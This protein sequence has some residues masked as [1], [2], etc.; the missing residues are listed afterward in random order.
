MSQRLKQLIAKKDEKIAR[1]E[2]ISALAADENRELTAEESTEIDACLADSEKLTADIDRETKLVNATKARL[3]AAATSAASRIQ[4][5]QNAGGETRRIV[6]P[7]EARRTGTLKCFDGP[8]AE[9]D[10]YISGQWALATIYDRQASREWLAD[11]GFGIKNALTTSDESSAGFLVPSPLESAIIRRVETYGVFRQN[12]GM[13]KPMTG[14]RWAGPRRLSGV[15]VYYPGE[16][17]AGT[18]STPTGGTISLQARDAVAWTKVSR[19]IEADAVI[20]IGD[21]LADEFGLAYA[22]AEDQ[23]GFNGDGT[24]TY[25]GMV[26]LKNKLAAGSIYTCGAGVNTFGEITNTDFQSVVGMLPEYA[27]M[28]PKWYMSKAG[29]FASAARLQA[30]AGGNTKMDI[31][32]GP[33]YQ[34]EGYEVVW[35]HVLPNALTDLASTIVAYFGDLSYA[36]AMGTA[37][38]MSIES[39]MSKYFH[40]RMIAVQAFSRYDINVYEIGTAS[41]A[42]ACI[43]LKLGTA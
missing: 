42:G 40:E 23:A 38:G 3:Q 19:N 36:A 4:E 25:G 12:V 9:K 8:D 1:A 14:G 5:P 27:G 6:I 13:Q 43:A 16:G 18:E 37:R 7:A 41:T 22:I 2:T 20:A 15:T 31:G 17:V 34:I 30:A 21:W 39:D 24:S 28:R 33:V 10:A 11:N 29:F 26:G 35:T 32:N